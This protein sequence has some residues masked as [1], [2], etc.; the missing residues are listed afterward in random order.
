MPPQIPFPLTVAIRSAGLP[1]GK[2]IATS[3]R[4]NA[5]MRLCRSLRQGHYFDFDLS[6]LLSHG[7]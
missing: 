7:L 2:T 3:Y 1:S 5:S 6:P 4:L